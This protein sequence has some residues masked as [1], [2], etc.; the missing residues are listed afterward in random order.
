MI[1]LLHVSKVFGEGP[2]RVPALS[3]VSF[4]VERGEFVVLSGGSGTVMSVSYLKLPS[5]VVGW[6]TV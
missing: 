2:A 6:G 4:T 1:R 3:D 5:L